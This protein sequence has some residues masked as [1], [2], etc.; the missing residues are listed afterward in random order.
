MTRMHHHRHH[1]HHHGGNYAARAAMAM[2][3]DQQLLAIQPGQQVVY[4]DSYAHTVKTFNNQ[5]APNLVQSYSL[6][7]QLFTDTMNS[8]NTY[9][10]RTVGEIKSKYFMIMMINIILIVLTCGLWIFVYIFVMFYMIYQQQQKQLEVKQEVNKMFQGLNNSQLTSNGFEWKL[11]HVST[12][13][14]L[15][16]VYTGTANL[17]MPPQQPMMIQQPY[18]QPYQQQ[19]MLVPP[20]QQQFIPTPSSASSQ[21]MPQGYGTI[22]PPGMVTQPV[23]LQPVTLQPVTIGV[24]DQ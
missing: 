24:K 10:D 22:N 17:T 21:P 7:G 19:P 23:T 18:G 4:E 13:I 16:L 15:R 5:L 6:D 11:I 1:H 8:L 14:V 3:M 12:G 20:Q 2:A 9:L